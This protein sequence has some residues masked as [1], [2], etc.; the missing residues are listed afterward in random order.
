VRPTRADGDAVSVR[1]AIALGCAV[2]ATAVG[3]RPPGC[4]LVPP[5]DVAALAAR[6]AEAAAAPRAPP[7]ER[8]ADPFDALLG[9]YAAL[10]APAPLPD[11]GRRPVRAPTF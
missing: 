6:L 9:I 3:H 7:R 8:G 11:G 1:E 5:G 10:G 4:L 2:V